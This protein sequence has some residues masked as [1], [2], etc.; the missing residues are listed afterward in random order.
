MS[1]PRIKAHEAVPRRAGRVLALIVSTPFAAHSWTHPESRAL[2]LVLGAILLWTLDVLPDF[3][4]ALGLIAAWNIAAVGPSAASL[5]GFASP[6][7][8]HDQVRAFSLLYVALSLAG[9][10]VSIPVWRWLGLL[11]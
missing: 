6:V 5:S 10:V 7:C 9:L 2:V 4:V 3:V 8:A 1:T 11:A